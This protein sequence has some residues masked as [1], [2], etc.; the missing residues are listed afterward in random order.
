MS[1]TIELSVDVPQDVLNT[2]LDLADMWGE[3]TRDD[4]FWRC[5]ERVWFVTANPYRNANIASLPS[6]K[7]WV[8]TGAQ[9][10][11]LVSLSVDISLFT[12]NQLNDLAERWEIGLGGI[13]THCIRWAFDDHRRRD[14]AAKEGANE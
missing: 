14:A 7:D 10:S 6:V 9:S 13:V 5:V 11:S 2:L 8:Y 12:L 4:A 3:E 1:E